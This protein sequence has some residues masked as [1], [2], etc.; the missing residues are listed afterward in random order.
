MSQGRGQGWQSAESRVTRLPREKLMF[1][2]HRDR[3]LREHPSAPGPPDPRPIRERLLP[4]GPLRPR[5]GA[6]RRQ[7]RPCSSGAAGAAA[8]FPRSDTKRCF[9]FEF[10]PVGSSNC[11]M[12]F[13]ISTALCLSSKNEIVFSRRGLRE[14]TIRCVG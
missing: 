9:E 3:L 6:R 1:S 10:C 2:H 8:H 11:R 7:N 4:C 12:E 13:V 5:G 14:R